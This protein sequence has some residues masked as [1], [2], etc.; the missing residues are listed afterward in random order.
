MCGS[1]VS[2]IGRSGRRLAPLVFLLPGAL[3][4]LDYALTLSSFIDLTPPVV[5]H[6]ISTG[7]L[8]CGKKIPL[9]FA[10]TCADMITDE[11]TIG[12][13]MDH[14]MPAPTG[15]ASSFDKVLKM[16][17]DMVD[18]KNAVVEFCQGCL[19]FRGVA[20]EHL[21]EHP[22]NKILRVVNENVLKKC[23]ETFTEM[24]EKRDDYKKFY[25]QFGKSLNW[26]FTRSCR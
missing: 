3:V 11:I 5:I 21:V 24:A 6:V 18:S 17:D 15:K 22:R 19:G 25:E 26:T 16:T 8:K 23:L 4:A 9:D 13:P 20:T 2:V 7:A 12:S 10:P 14:V 1:V